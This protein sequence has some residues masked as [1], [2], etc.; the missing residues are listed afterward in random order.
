[1]KD[2]IALVGV[3]SVHMQVLEKLVHEGY[4]VLVVNRNFENRYV[5]VRKPCAMVVPYGNPAAAPRG[6]MD[7]LTVLG[8]PRRRRSAVLVD[9]NHSPV[10]SG[11][12]S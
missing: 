3:G 5:S 8:W 12:P 4:E 2:H 6:H 10:P 7:E 9:Q 11:C 1:M